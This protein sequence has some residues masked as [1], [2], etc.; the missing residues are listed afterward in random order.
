MRTEARSH[1]TDANNSITSRRALMLAASIWALLTFGAMSVAT[2]QPYAVG[3]FT[4][5][6]G[7]GTSGGG[8]YILSGTVGQPDTGT[9]TGGSFTVEGGFWPGFVVPSTNGGPTL[10]VQLFGNGLIISWSPAV[11]GF[12]LEQTE[13]LTSPSWSAAPTGNPTVPIPASNGTR[14]YRLRKL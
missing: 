11:T 10:F 4:I 7:G 8:N 2:A 9:L 5:N 12:V 6:G 3:R 1:R 14:F 13:S